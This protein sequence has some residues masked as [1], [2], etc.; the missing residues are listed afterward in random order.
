MANDNKVGILI[1]LGIVAIAL[2][3]GSKG[4]QANGLISSG[5]PTP[6]QKEAN[7]QQNIAQAQAQVEDLKRQIQLEE[8][9]KTQSEYK[10]MVNIY[11]INRSSNPSQEYVA[12]RANISGTRTIPV[13]GW[14]LKSISS[15]T[16]VTIPK[17]S[18]LY[19]ANSVNSEEDIY[20]NSNDTLYLISGLSPIG[21]SFKNNKCSGY[22]NQFQTFVPYLGSSCPAPRDEN[23][24]SIPKTPVNDV[25][26][27]YI[28]SAPN[29][30]IKTE[31]APANW[32]SECID[33]V[34]NKINYPSCVNIH[35]GDKDFYGNEWRVYLRYTDRIWKDSREHIVLYDNVGKIVD[36]IKY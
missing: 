32:S 22:L 35:R 3:G 24:Y 25:C 17:A 33:F 10:G 12:I 11:F 29:C 21:V 19:F 6:E 8:D 18:Y 15:G 2:L 27:D 7:I 9:K 20:L 30:R 14:T 26:F 5:T 13:T 34:Y 4:P 31:S 36:E 16:S 28:E 1:I 23:L